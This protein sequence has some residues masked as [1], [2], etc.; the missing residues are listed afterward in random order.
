MRVFLG[1]IEALESTFWA[2]V[3][4]G[5]CTLLSMVVSRTPLSLIMDHCLSTT[6]SLR[7]EP[8]VREIMPT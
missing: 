8:Q 2:T 6:I 1:L 7:Q 4:A 3:S 5:H